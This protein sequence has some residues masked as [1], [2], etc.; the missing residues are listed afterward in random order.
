MAQES[1]SRKD[2]VSKYMKAGFTYR[3]SVAAYEATCELFGDAISQ[4]A[5]INI[6][7]VCCLIPKHRPAQEVKM[8]FVKEKQVD[9]SV[10]TKKRQKSYY[11]DP[12]VSYKVRIFD[13]FKHTHQLHWYA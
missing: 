4:A 2:F 13:S 10:V 5:K 12:R 1:F 8:N 6:G 9:G 3:D 11:L 7:N